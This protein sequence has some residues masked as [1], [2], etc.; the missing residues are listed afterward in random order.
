MSLTLRDVRGL[1]DVL[2]SNHDW[3]AV[4]RDYAAKHDR[5]YGVIHTVAGGYKDLFS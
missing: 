2:W 4:G 5:Y 1:R 3:D